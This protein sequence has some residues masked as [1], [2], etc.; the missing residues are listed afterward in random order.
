MFLSTA[1]PNCLGTPP[2]LESA[3][4]S[5]Q[6]RYVRQSANLFDR[7]G[8]VS[9]SLSLQSVQEE[10]EYMKCDDAPG[11]GGGG[12]YAEPMTVLESQVIDNVTSSTFSIP[13]LVTLD[14]DEKDHKVTISILNFES[15]IKFKVYPKVSLHTFL[16]ASA[17]NTSSFPLL[18][19]S[20]KVFHANSYICETVIKV[21][22]SFFSFPFL[23]DR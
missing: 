17:L 10:C 11:G 2:K 6:P 5:I 3:V 22:L 20:A 23:F 21:P 8:S 9:K 18:S 15:K 12:D 14:S 4:L 13:R 7:L 16:K 19:G 1:T